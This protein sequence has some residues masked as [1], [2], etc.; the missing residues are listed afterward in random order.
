MHKRRVRRRIIID[1]DAAAP[2]PDCLRRRADGIW[3]QREAM[4][5]S[6]VSAIAGGATAISGSAAAAAA[7]HCDQPSVTTTLALLAAARS[8]IRACGGV[9]AIPYAGASCSE[10]LHRHYI[11]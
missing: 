9:T 8:L 6:R 4:W 7:A 11:T 5:A 1:Q 10:R 3:E 2:R